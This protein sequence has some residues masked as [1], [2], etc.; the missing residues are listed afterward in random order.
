MREKE[1]R[2]GEGKRRGRKKKRT[3]QNDTRIVNFF[4]KG[5]LMKTKTTKRD[6]KQVKDQV[7]KNDPRFRI[8]VVRRRM[9]QR[10]N[11]RK[12]IK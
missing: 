10:L 1:S 6:N 12:K 8:N 3:G 9:K 7:T 4:I 11:V 2:R 5:S